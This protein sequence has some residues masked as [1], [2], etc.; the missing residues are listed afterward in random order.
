MKKIFRIKNKARKTQ[1]S[2]QD[3][4]IIA[5]ARYTYIS[6]LIFF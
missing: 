6:T 1:T 2:T 4:T 3:I 5:R